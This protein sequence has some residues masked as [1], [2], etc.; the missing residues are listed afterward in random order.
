MILGTFIAII[1]IVVATVMDGHSF[2]AL[3]GPS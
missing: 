3:I 1:S 2:D